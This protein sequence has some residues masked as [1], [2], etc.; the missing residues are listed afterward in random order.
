MPDHVHVVLTPYDH[1]TLRASVTRIKRY[2]SHVMRRRVWQREWFD[3]ILRS[4]EDVRA[5][6]VYVCMNPFDAG[7]CDSI[8]DY[9]WIW[10]SWLQ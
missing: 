9:P 2:T 4:D 7:I 8:D 6:C 10:R 1:R 3:R 5:K